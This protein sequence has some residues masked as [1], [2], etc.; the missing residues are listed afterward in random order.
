MSKEIDIFKIQASWLSN[1]A[2]TVFLLYPIMAVKYIPF[3][4][5]ARYMTVLAGPLAIIILL[6]NY[7]RLDLKA[8]LNRAKVFLWPFLPLLLGLGFAVLYHHQDLEFKSTILSV[9]YGCMIYLAAKELNLSEKQLAYA[10]CIGAV[11]YFATSI[12][13]VNFIGRERAF[14][15]TYENGFAQF[16]M[17]INGFALIYILKTKG[18]VINV[19]NIVL[20]LAML[21]SFYALVLS[22][23]RGPLLLSPLLIIG[24]V[25]RYWESRLFIM[26]SFFFIIIIVLYLFFVNTLYLDRLKLGADEAIQYFQAKQ[27]MGS[28]VGIRLELWKLAF[29]TVSIDRPFGLGRMTFSEMSHVIPELSASAINLSTQF[30]VNRWQYHGDIP[31]AIGFGGVLLC[32]S[33][34]IT[35]FLLFKGSIGNVYRVWLVVCLFVFGLTEL[36]VFSKYSFS[37]FVSCWALYSAA[38]DTRLSFSMSQSE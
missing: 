22:G 34:A 17:M 33:Y 12:Y 5:G 23:S 24:C 36:T 9:F 15:G 11:I 16:C 18:N 27:Y 37:L 35:I 30:P 25:R 6:V 31:Q 38:Q 10:A 14:G 26:G 4:G 13:E 19:F 29:G 28:S 3:G 32:I 8:L 7:K 1:I 21:G 2:I 20:G